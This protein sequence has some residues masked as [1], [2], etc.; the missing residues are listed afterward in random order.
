MHTVVALIHSFIRSRQH[1]R[2]VVVGR[3]SPYTWPGARGDN[4]MLI[5]P[6]STNPVLVG[7]SFGAS[8]SEYVTT[9][10]M[11]MDMTYCVAGCWDCAYETGVCNSCKSGFYL[12]VDG[13]KNQCIVCATNCAS[14]TST[15]A[16]ACTSCNTGYSLS[17]TGSCVTTCPSW[18]TS[19]CRR[20]ALRVRVVAPLV[21]LRQL[22]PVPR[23]PLA[24]T[25]MLATAQRHAR[26]ILR[27]IASLYS[28]HHR[29]F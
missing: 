21:P 11:A 12:Y 16:T 13:S 18:A 20:C 1:N 2:I 9:I 27:N 24:T 5:D 25:C 15:S 17:P 28:V 29:L 7:G 14:C 8:T 10:W 6:V 23:V 26:R 19:R 3:L 22:D 4:V